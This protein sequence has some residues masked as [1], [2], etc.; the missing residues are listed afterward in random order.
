M[1]AREPVPLGGDD[2]RFSIGRC[3][4]GIRLA[5]P[6]AVGVDYG[7]EPDTRRRGQVHL[8]LVSTF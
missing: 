6:E 5:T 2:S 1:A 7:L 3:R 4:F 8:Q